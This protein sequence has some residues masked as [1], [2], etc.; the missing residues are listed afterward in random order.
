MKQE[1]RGHEHVVE[2]SVFAPLAAYPALRELA[3]SQANPKGDKSTHGLYLAT[4]SRD[5]TVKI[6][7]TISG[8][9]IKTLNGHE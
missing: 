9:C 3:G 7:D 6:W 8:Q 1:L 2:C 5:K 4:G